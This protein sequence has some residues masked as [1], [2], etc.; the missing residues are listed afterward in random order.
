MQST[1]RA[2]WESSSD[3]QRR[4]SRVLRG[5]YVAWPLAV[6]GLVWAAA[7]ATP[8]EPE[9]KVHVV[10]IEGLKWVPEVLVVNRGDRVTWINKDPFPHTV[11][12][13]DKTFDSGNLASGLSWNLVAEA[14]GS[15]VYG[16][17][18]HP[19]MKGTLIVRAQANAR[20]HQ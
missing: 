11:S 15:H 2:R 10:T 7:G 9:A 19:T 12:A 4:R 5:G 3:R 20:D 16:C 14:T 8:A 6:T 13:A 1:Y 18:L 17:L